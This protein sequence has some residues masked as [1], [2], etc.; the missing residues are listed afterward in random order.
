MRSLQFPI[1]LGRMPMKF[2]YCYYHVRSFRTSKTFCKR[3]FPHT[4]LQSRRNFGEYYV[5]YTKLSSE[6]LVIL[7][8]LETVRIIEEKQF[9]IENRCSREDEWYSC[10]HSY[11]GSYSNRTKLSVHLCLDYL[12]VI[13]KFLRQSET[14]RSKYTLSFN[15]IRES[16]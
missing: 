1:D 16:Q 4:T 14:K 12:N 7:S 6:K 13:T 15:Q 11:R 9:T 10:F 5:Y 3:F 8:L 2:R